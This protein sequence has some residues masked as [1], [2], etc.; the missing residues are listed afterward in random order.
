VAPRIAKVALNV[1]TT[2]MLAGE[3]VADA[4]RRAENALEL[5]RD[6]A[7]LNASKTA[8]ALAEFQLPDPQVPASTSVT[9]LNALPVGD[10]IFSG[11]R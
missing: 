2:Q 8:E 3:T 11:A 7:R 1:G 4:L 9:G 6:A 5:A 10:V